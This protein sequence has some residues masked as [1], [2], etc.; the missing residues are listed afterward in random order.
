MGDFLS[1]PDKTN[2]EVKSVNNS[3]PASD[4]KEQ[5]PKKNKRKMNFSIFSRGSAKDTEEYRNCY[6]GKKDHLGLDDNYRFYMNEIPS[7][8][9]GDLIDKIHLEWYDDYKLLERHHG[10]IQWLFPIRDTGMNW[11]AQELQKHEIQKIRKNK[12]AMKRVLQSYKMM[13]GFYGMKLVNEED[14]TV[15]RAHNWRERFSH[16]NSSFH[17]YLRIT[18][19]LKSLGELGYEHLKANWVKFIIHEGFVEE[20]LPNC[21]ESCHRFWIGVIREDRE[22]DELYELFE[23]YA[24]G[25]GLEKRKCSEVATDV[26]TEDKTQKG[27]A[28]PAKAG[29]KEKHAVKDYDSDDSDQGMRA[30]MGMLDEEEASGNDTDQVEGK[31]KQKEHEISESEEEVDE[32]SQEL[33]HLRKESELENGSAAFDDSSNEN[34]HKMEDDAKEGEGNEDVIVTGLA[35]DATGH[36]DKST[37][38]VDNVN[39]DENSLVSNGGGQDD[40]TKAAAADDDD[41]KDEGKNDV[42][43]GDKFEDG[44]GDDNKIDKERNDV[45]DGDTDTG[46]V[47]MHCCSDGNTGT[48]SNKNDGGDNSVGNKNVAE[49]QNVSGEGDTNET[50]EKVDLKPK[51][52]D[53]GTCMEVDDAH[54]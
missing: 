37:G 26:K 3:K 15:E 28:K 51:E 13:L 50:N 39:D 36:V 43:D 54:I 53:D 32:E 38:L 52:K 11:Q 41:E 35:D 40:A 4:R 45:S 7:K 49:M 5:Q 33:K 19:I 21:L 10:Y 9:S 23:K 22:R 12:K 16:L 18:R 48:A 24:A 47:N 8:P 29:K 14:G 27:S 46:D 25:E 1:K 30:A 44:V 20:T 31:T 6:P 42:G 17:N 34:D 2:K